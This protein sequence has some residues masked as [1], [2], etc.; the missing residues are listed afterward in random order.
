MK[1]GT[2]GKLNFDH[3][4][5]DARPTRFLSGFF[6]NLHEDRD[7]LAYGYNIRAIKAKNP[8]SITGC[9]LLSKQMSASKPA[10]IELKSMRSFLD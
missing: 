4:H 5:N 10:A 2:L 8:H 1:S 7:R 6:L 9:G 3:Q